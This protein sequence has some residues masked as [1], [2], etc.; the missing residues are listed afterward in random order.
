MST[1]TYRENWNTVF[2]KRQIMTPSRIAKE[3]L[4]QL[5]NSLVMGNL[6]HRDYD[7][8]PVKFVVTGG[9]VS[10]RQQYLDNWMAIFNWRRGTG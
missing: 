9:T 3:A 10:A 7:R 5:E 2:G 4:F 1:E 6:V 8:R